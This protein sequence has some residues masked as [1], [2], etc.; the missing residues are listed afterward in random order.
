MGDSSEVFFSGAKRVGCLGP[1][2]Q[3]QEIHCFGGFWQM[4]IPL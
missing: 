2:G 4:C 3:M 1:M